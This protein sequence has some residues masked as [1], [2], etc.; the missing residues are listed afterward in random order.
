MKVLRICVDQEYEGVVVLE[1]SKNSATCP[2]GALS[3][4]QSDDLSWWEDA[5]GN[6]DLDE[7]QYYQITG[8]EPAE[9]DVFLLFYPDN[10]DISDPRQILFNATRTVNFTQ[11]ARMLSRSVYNKL[12]GYD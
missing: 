7:D 5:G 9:S 4:A 1:V 8:R 2:V 3:Q 12:L 6:V 11:P 10:V